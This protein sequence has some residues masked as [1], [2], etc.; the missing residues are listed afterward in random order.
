MSVTHLILG[1]QPRDKAAMLG[2]RTI[3]CFLEAVNMKI[4]FS[5]QKREMLFF[6]AGF[7][8]TKYVFQ[9]LYQSLNNKK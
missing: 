2:I 1:L 3:K 6:L 5:S 9:A 7:C 4:E 8:Q